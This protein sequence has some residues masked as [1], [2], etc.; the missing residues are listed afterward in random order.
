M[1]TV[2]LTRAQFQSTPP[3]REATRVAVAQL[4]E[5]IISIHASLAGGDHAVRLYRRRRNYF[6]PRLPRGRR[7]GSLHSEQ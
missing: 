6:N 3:S 2:I 7:P 1:T 4:P 5:H